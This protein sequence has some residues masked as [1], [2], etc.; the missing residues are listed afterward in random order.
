MTSKES[1]FNFPLPITYLNDGIV[2]VKLFKVHGYTVTSKLVVSFT[3]GK[4][5]KKALTYTVFFPISD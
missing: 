5:A 3:S 1:D 4:F 2:K